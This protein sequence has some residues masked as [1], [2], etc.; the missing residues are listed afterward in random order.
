MKKK[1]VTLPTILGLLVAVVGLVSGLWLLNGRLRQSAEA[2]VEEAPGEIRVVNVNDTGFTVIWL[3]QKSVSGFVQYGE[4]GAAPDLVVSDERDQQKGV[5]GSYF[6][7]FVSVR[8]LKPATKYNWRIGSGKRVYDQTGKPYETTTAKQLDGPPPAD[9]AYGQIVTESAE[10]AEGALVYL[11]MTGM[12]PQAAL[13]KAS[14]SWVIPL[15]TARN[16]DL[17][18][19]STYD[20]NTAEM[21][22]IV[23]G[24]PLGTSQVKVTTQNDSPV[25]DVI[26]G[27]SY[28]LVAGSQKT[29]EEDGATSKFSAD[30]LGPAT[31]VAGGGTGGLS[32]HNGEKEKK[33]RTG[34]RGEG[35]AR[36]AR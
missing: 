25:P 17:S 31:E 29:G 24:G 7:H 26:L 12:T 30:S 1:E 18:S 15:S 16:E 22:I 23:Q 19:F 21:E 36:T 32:S 9:V 8:G 3:T 11:T 14:G 20:K 5:I 35:G 6:T 4:T 34:P 27:R 13:V 2:E 28:D 33:T 10:P